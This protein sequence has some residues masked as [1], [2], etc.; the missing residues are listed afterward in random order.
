MKVILCWNGLQSTTLRSSLFKVF[1]LLRWFVRSPLKPR[2]SP[3]GGD[4]SSDF[5][6]GGGMKNPTP[7]QRRVTEQKSAECAFYISGKA[8]LKLLP[9]RAKQARHLKSRTLPGSISTRV[10]IDLFVLLRLRFVSRH[11]A[12]P[13]VRSKRVKRSHH[14]T[15]TSYAQILRTSL[16]LQPAWKRS[17]KEQHFYHYWGLLPR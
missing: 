13:A 2:C 12:L 14:A 8:E 16:L 15:S 5:P 17:I 6:L 11:C 1:L 4:G 3:E 9:Y 10:K 7:C